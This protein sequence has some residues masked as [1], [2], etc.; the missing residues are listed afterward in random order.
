MPEF[1]PF[2]TPH[3]EE[4][5]GDLDV[6]ERHRKFFHTHLIFVLVVVF[7]C[8]LYSAISLQDG[9]G[10]ILSFDTTYALG[11]GISMIL[12]DKV[13]P[14]TP[15]RELDARVSRHRCLRLTHLAAVT[16]S[17]RHMQKWEKA[18]ENMRSIN[19]IAFSEKPDNGEAQQG[20]SD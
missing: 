18:Y 11:I 4:I 19:R 12:A 7:A 9:S 13:F 16:G 20:I 1:R 6:M 8:I 5:E 14:W 15:M 17:P 10:T 2:E 3:P